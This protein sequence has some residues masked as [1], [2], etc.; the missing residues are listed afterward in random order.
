MIIFRY[1]TVQFENTNT[2]QK[3]KYRIPNTV[4]YKYK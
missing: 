1:V 4:K 2:N 3:K